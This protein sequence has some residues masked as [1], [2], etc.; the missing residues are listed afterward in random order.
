MK[1]SISLIS[2]ILISLLGV[3]CVGSKKTGVSV[4]Q[5][6]GKGQPYNDPYASS[7]FYNQ[8]VGDPYVPPTGGD[9]GIEPPAPVSNYSSQ[10]TY[11]APS[12]K[13]VHTVA[14]GDTLYSISRNYGTTVAA[15]Q[16]ANG[17]NGSLIRIGEKI[18]IP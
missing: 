7:D 14:K 18:M 3:S 10:P 12:S 17:I 8:P 11:T 9:F 13:S 15:L 1:N 4:Y 16:Q 2:L 5:D 6:K